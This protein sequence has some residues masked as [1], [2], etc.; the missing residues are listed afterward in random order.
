MIAGGHIERGKAMICMVMTLT[1][2]TGR[3]Q[4]AMGL[5]SDFVHNACTESSA[6][7]AHLYQS[8]REPRH[9]LMHLQ[10]ADQQTADAYR[11]TGYY[12]EH[13]MTDLYSLLEC[14][15]FTLE[16]Y[17]PVIEVGVPSLR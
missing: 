8:R 11:D 13:I 16:T 5:L 17:E 6:L 3:E 2:V 10:F 7:A 12:G 14:D 1:V 4:T 15:S 9:F